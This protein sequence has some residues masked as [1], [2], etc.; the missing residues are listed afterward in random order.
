LR[1]SFLW[2]Y[3]ILS[4]LI[5][6]LLLLT[7]VLF[8]FLDSPS[9][10]LGLLKTP[11]QEQ[12][13]E[14]G[15]MKG[16]LLSG[17]VLKDVNY[18]N[19][20]KAKMLKVKIDL[21]KL[22]ERIL[23][24]DNVKIENLEVEEKFLASL[25]DVNSSSSS[26]SNSTLPFDLIV[27]N[28][29]D[30]SLLNM[31]YE[32][33][34]INRVNLKINHL[35]SD[36]KKS[37][38]GDFFLNMDSNIANIDISGKIKN[39]DYVVH[40]N[41]EGEQLFLNGFLKENNVTLSSNPKFK[42]LINGDIKNLNYELIIKELIVEQNKYSANSEK[43][44]AKGEYDFKNESLKTDII[45]S[46]KSNVADFKLK[47]KSSVK[48]NDIN[49]S[50]AFDVN[51]HLEPKELL[52]SKELKEQNLS[53][54]S[55]PY[56]NF[57]S[58]GSLKKSRFNLS[59]KELKVKQNEIAL[60][61]KNLDVKGDVKALQGDLNIELLSHFDST[62]ANGF[63]EG[64]TALNFKDVNNSLTFNVQTKI[65]V[66]PKYVNNLLVDSNVTIL[67]K[68]PIELNAKGDFSQLKV[69][70]FAKSKVKTQGI[71]ST[72]K[73][74]SSELEVK[75][76]E[77]KI[78][79]KLYVES[80]SKKV[81]FDL[82]SN[83]DGD[84][85]NIEK[86][87]T[88]IDLNLRHFNAF[89]VNLNSLTPLALK[90]KNSQD[91]AILNL[92]SK[93]I[94]LNAK[95]KDFDNFIFDIK[96]DNIYPY[97][98]VKLPKELE[99]KF[100]KLNLEGSSLL[101][102]EY[103]TL[104]GKVESNKGFKLDLEGRNKENGLAVK[105]TTK[106]L[107]LEAKGD[108]TKKDIHLVLNIDSLKKLQKEFTALYSFEPLLIDGSVKLNTALKEEKVSFEL[109]SPKLKFD[110]FNMEKIALNGDYLNEL[111][112][113]DKLSFNTAGF[114][115]KSLNQH[116]YLNQK[117]LI[118]L[119]EKRDVLLDM[120]P[121]I[122]LKAKGNSENLKASIQ[123]ETLPLGHNEYGNMVLSCDIDYVQNLNKKTIQGGIF[124]DNL[125]LFYESKFLDPSADNDVIILT[126]KDKSKK[127][128]V[129]D[130][131][132]NT[133]V[134][135]NLYASDAEYKTRDIELEFTVNVKAKKE[136]GKSLRML[137]KVQE[138]EGRVEQAPKLFTVVDSNLVFR[139]VKDPNPL[140]DITVE[141]KLPD[142]LITIKIHGNAKR[143]K[144]SFSSEPPLPKKDILSY[145]VLG[146]STANLSEGKGSLGREAQLFILNQAAR[147]LAYEVEL[148]RVFIKDDGTGEGFAIQVGKKINEKSI[149]VIENS[150]E[151]NSLI[152]E[153]DINKN[154]KLE[155]GHHQK[156]VPSQSIDLFF[157][158]RFK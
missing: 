86:L 8:S 34:K 12:G 78:K 123:V 3:Y 105:L 125:K 140:L 59:I 133:A 66:E 95:S 112:T 52:F 93:K 108:L 14:Y 91:G 42:L 142:V 79:G 4:W 98:I 85:L 150:K 39:D 29:L 53:F 20:V 56:V 80:N 67:E 37:H 65:E 131:L 120:H 106:T 24:I 139:G 27:V 110:G 41:V 13:I 35:K 5:L 44:V 64:K 130:F 97:K 157:R 57:Q 88:S 152:L 103:F 73:L 6:L 156:T 38:K 126:K 32:E 115:P 102:K 134:D 69:K 9:M 17:F 82:K 136:F 81:A 33:Y 21:R 84:Y 113:L 25:L 83:F 43:F 151:G 101:S 119:G 158:K 40:G 2:L 132:E 114:K 23:Y 135:V 100:I 60:D 26:E 68:T 109:S 96:T 87:D 128:N 124:L 138:I 54:E 137:G 118:N 36:M 45:S 15:E 7:V 74:E 153:Y 107:K 92:N 129:D 116:Y 51:L 154:I 75:V 62:V 90:I 18:N 70:V 46:I 141:H 147:D 10:A 127:K 49:S 117:A 89:D 11:L 148:D 71:V 104:M 94:K 146:V 28:N 77:H 1:K 50:L 155:I 16:S 99:K 48:L 72:V 63:V 121:K 111:L 122:L 22:E 149:V 58:S 19:Q 76:N 145:L 55:M 30:F 61:I 144:L 143:P 31:Q 47:A